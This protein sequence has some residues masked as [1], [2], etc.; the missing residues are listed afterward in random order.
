MQ[1]R[2]TWCILNQAMNWEWIIYLGMFLGVGPL[3]IEVAGYVWH[4]FVEHWGVLGEGLTFRHWMHHEVAYPA[5]RLRTDIYD[6]ARS[7]GWYVLLGVIGGGFFLVLPTGR[8]LAAAL[9]A[10]LYGWVVINLFHAA[11]H[12]RGHFWWRLAWFRRLA[13]LHDI[14]HYAP[15]NYG[16]MF[17]GIDRLCGTYRE[18]FPRRDW[19]I[20]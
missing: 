6:D 14:H 15:A 8:A 3:A 2:P 1:S 10:T 11:F 20:F 13:R 12:V 7:W 5:D 17:F 4:R 16:I 19:T 18:T 9:G